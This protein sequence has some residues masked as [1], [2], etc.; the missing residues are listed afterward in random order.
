MYPLPFN[1]R[2]IELPNFGVLSIISG[3]GVFGVR[4]H[5]KNT[6]LPRFIEMIRILHP[7][8]ILPQSRCVLRRQNPGLPGSF[9]NTSRIVD[10]ENE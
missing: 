2:K 6:R 3:Q 10:L 1:S 7:F 5:A 4:T 9:I 8:G